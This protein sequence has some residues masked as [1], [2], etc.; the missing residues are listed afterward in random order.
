MAALVHPANSSIGQVEPGQHQQVRSWLHPVQ[1]V[2]VAGVDLEHRWRR[3]CVRLPGRV[4]DASE[5]RADDPDRLPIDCG[6]RLFHGP[7]S[8]EPSG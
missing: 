6:R 1:R 5:A 4:L 8:L 2:G 7:G 3:S